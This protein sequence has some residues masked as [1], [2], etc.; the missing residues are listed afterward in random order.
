MKILIA[1]DSFKGTFSAKEIA[2]EMRHAL[3]VAC[4]ADARIQPLADGG[5]GTAQVLAEAL[6][7]TYRT[8]TVTGPLGE[9]V[10]ASYAVAGETALIEMAAAAGLPLVPEGQLNPAWATTYG[11]GE[12]VC[13]AL[14]T[15]VAKIILG[16]GG[17]ATVDGGAGALQ[18]LGAKLLGKNGQ[19]I[20][21]GNLGLGELKKIDLS[22]AI[23]KI[24]STMLIL[25]T[26]VRNPLLGT[27]GA[28]RIFGPQKGVRLHD[29]DSFE[30]RLEHYA[31]LIEMATGKVIRGT[32]GTGAAGGLAFGLLAVGGRIVPGFAL[33]SEAV[34]LEEK[35]RE[36]DLVI[37]GEGK[38]DKTSLSGKVVGNV[39][40]LCRKHHVRCWVVAGLSDFGE[41]DVQPLGLEKIVTLFDAPEHNLHV[42]KE[43][44][45]LKLNAR[46]TTSF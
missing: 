4:Q 21:K 3:P 14:E 32:P 28:A 16:L 39:I 11:V 36:A 26:D 13:H 10:I 35:V 2:M 43:Q 37:T 29:I 7:A 33:V 20:S 8:V 40:G 15:G 27:N 42:L 18:A 44:T 30:S 1:P 9:P 19:D 45:P 34:G 41:K 12:L 23:S 6:N 24:K 46:F 17:S 5:E 22:E 38:F 31:D 25:A